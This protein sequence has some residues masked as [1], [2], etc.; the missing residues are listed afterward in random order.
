MTLAPPN[1]RIDWHLYFSHQKK[2]CDNLSGMI[3]AWLF[4]GGPKDPKHRG[5]A[6][7]LITFILHYGIVALVTTYFHD[8]MVRRYPNFCEK[9]VCV[10]PTAAVDR[11]QYQVAIF[12]GLYGCCLLLSRLYLRWHNTCGRGRGLDDMFLEFYRQT[13]LCSVTIF[14]SALGLYTGRP[15]LTQAFCVAVGIDQLLWWIDLGGYILWYVM[16]THILMKL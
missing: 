15:I 5:R 2:K 3:I 16:V 11:R 4:H 10:V 9:G 6:H 12:F 1:H 8:W 7:P 13:F 14:H